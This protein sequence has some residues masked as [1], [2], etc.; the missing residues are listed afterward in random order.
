MR[1]EHLWSNQWE[2]A[3]RSLNGFNTLSLV[4]HEVVDAVNTSR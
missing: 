4:V 1:G 3:L 2:I